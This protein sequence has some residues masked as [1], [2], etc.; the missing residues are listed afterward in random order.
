MRDEDQRD[1]GGIGRWLLLAAVL[2][3]GG[4]GAG[5]YFNGDRISDQLH[6]WLSNSGDG[7][8]AAVPQPRTSTA[9]SAD[10]AALTEMPALAGTGTGSTSPEEW[11]DLSPADL[12]AQGAALG[13]RSL[14]DT[15]FDQ[16]P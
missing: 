16:P 1:T 4:A 11:P 6:Y 12:L 9:P 8:L 14:K 10:P 15:A 13:D 5:V 7:D 2:L 3:V